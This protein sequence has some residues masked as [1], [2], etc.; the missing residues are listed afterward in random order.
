MTAAL[1]AL[2]GVLGLDQTG[3]GQ[4]ML[5][6]P[7]VAGP[8]V[9]AIL[10]APVS[11]VLVGAIL[12]VLFLPAFPV[13]GA[14]FPETG[15]ATVVAAAAATNPGGGGLA[16]AVVLGVGWALL[17]GW[18]VTVLRRVN[19]GLVPA[20]GEER[21]EVARI[22]RGHLGAIALDFARAAGLTAVGLVVAGRVAAPLAR[23]WPLETGATI[24]LLGL[25]GAVS[26]GGLVAGLGHVRRRGPVVVG[27][28]LVGVLVGVIL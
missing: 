9:G 12:E 3:V 7:L 26:A 14:R 20:P 11:G 23:R 8:L 1:S 28:L 10:G 5:S 6:R 13:G 18:T 27:G 22:V 15:P 4:F 19:E 16:V 25:A 17:G 24:G 21:V 2:G